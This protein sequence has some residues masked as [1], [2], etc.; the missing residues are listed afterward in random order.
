MKQKR[1]RLEGGARDVPLCNRFA[2]TE[3]ATK[4]AVEL[5]EQWMGSTAAGST[6]RTENLYDVRTKAVDASNCSSGPRGGVWLYCGSRR[7]LIRR[8]HQGGRR[9]DHAPSLRAR[10]ADAGSARR[11]RQPL[12]IN[13]RPFIFR[14]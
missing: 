4:S 11:G 14:D 12:G 3:P 1:R 13:S 8:R 5:P 2:K 7:G 6:E 9:S 10:G